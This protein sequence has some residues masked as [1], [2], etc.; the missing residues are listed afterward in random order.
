MEHGILWDYRK[1]GKWR[2][3]G[4]KDG[5]RMQDSLRNDEVLN[6]WNLQN[7]A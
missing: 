5:K 6:A 2:H 7:D 1:M 3:C 4:M